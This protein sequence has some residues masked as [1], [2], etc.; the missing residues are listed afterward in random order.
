MG[1]WATKIMGIL[2]PVRN[3]EEPQYYICSTDDYYDNQ[4][5]IAYLQAKIQ[6]LKIEIH[7]LKNEIEEQ[8]KAHA[9]T[10]AFDYDEMRRIEEDYEIQISDREEYIDEL[11]NQLANMTQQRNWAISLNTD[12]IRVAKERANQAAGAKKKDGCGYFVKRT[13]MVKD[14]EM[15]AWKVT[16]ITPYAASMPLED[17]HPLILDDLTTGT[18]ILGQIGVDLLSAQ[19]GIYDDV[20]SDDGHLLC[21]A[22]KWTYTADFYQ[23]YWVISIWTNLSVDVPQYLRI[24]PKITP[25]KKGE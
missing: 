1:Y 10:M 6:D 23:N 13:D 8:I 12:L 9:D 3:G 18:S 4:D 22:Y 7:K 16:I 20:L 11:Q 5:Y 21:I 19:N 2:R 14:S 25:E 17:I 24:P 15:E